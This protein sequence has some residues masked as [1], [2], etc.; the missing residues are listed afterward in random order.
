MNVKQISV[1]VFFPLFLAM[2]P[3]TTHAAGVDGS[4]L[5]WPTYNRYRM[6]PFGECRRYAGRRF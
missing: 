6:G 1:G 3:L 2:A 5:L 4:S